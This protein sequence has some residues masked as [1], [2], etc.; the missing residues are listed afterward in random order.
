MCIRDSIIAGPHRRFRGHD[1]ADEFL[2]ILHRLPQIGIKSPLGDITVHMNKRILVALTLDTTLTLGKVSRSF[3]A[4][5][6]IHACLFRSLPLR[7][8]S[9]P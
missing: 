2:L 5:S 3:F 6:S 1:L 9:V 7:F 8:V 4:D